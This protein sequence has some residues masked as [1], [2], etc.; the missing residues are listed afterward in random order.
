MKLFLSFSKKVAVQT[1]V[2]FTL[3]L[4]LLFLIGSLIPDFAGAIEV[5]AIL[6]VFLFS[7]LLAC[8]NLLLLLERLPAALRVAL[9]YIASMLT[10]Y[11]VFILI[12]HRT[13]PQP[14]AL[15]IYFILFTLAYA[16]LLGAFLVF[17]NLRARKSPDKT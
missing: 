13:T 16:V 5:T 14:S 4:L 6:S 1:C 3:V 2:I 17:R 11:V 10:F 8:A 15:L 12:G 7:V 9:H